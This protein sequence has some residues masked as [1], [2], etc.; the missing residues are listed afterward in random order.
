MKKLLFLLIVLIALPALQS[1]KKGENDPLISFR[2][3]DARLI[4]SWK[5]V[6]VEGSYDRVQGGNHTY[7]TFTYDGYT[8]LD[9]I[10]NGSV[11]GTGTYEM[12][13]DKKGTMS[14]NE[15]LLVGNHT[16]INEGNGYWKWQ[17]TDKNKTVVNLVGGAHL[18]TSGDCMIDRLAYKELVIKRKY[19]TNDDGDTYSSDYTYTFEKE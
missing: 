17:N 3:R 4:G 8:F 13:I 15:T 14:W 11:G 16:L 18:F 10:S 12:T 1:C 2:S 19:N 5:L 7:S 9:D 6:K